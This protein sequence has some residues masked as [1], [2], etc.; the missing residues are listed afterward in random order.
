[1][2]GFSSFVGWATDAIR[3]VNEHAAAMDGRAAFVLGLLTWFVVEQAIRRLA[4][5]LRIAIIVGA[6]G[7]GGLGVAAAIAS[8]AGDP[9][10]PGAP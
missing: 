6:V 8:L 5:A 4:G 1:M 2:D 3:T 7:A 9:P 10:A